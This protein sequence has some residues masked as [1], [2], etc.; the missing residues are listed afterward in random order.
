MTEHSQTHGPATG[1]RVLH[2]ARAYDLGTFLLSF[3]R[4]KRLR[5]E[6]IQRA[7]ITTG[8]SVLDVGAGTGTLTIAAKA[9]V[10]AAGHV[11]GIDPSPEMI[12]RAKQKAAKA[13]A[14]IDFRLGVIESLPFPDAS[15]DAVLSSL[16]LHHLPDDVK[17]QGF[18]EIARVLKP[19]GRFFAVDMVGGGHGPAGHPLG[20][21]LGHRGH[22]GHGAGGDGLQSAVTLLQAAGF[23]DIVTGRLDSRAMFG[24]LSATRA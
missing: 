24:F 22:G 21:V 3:G 4:E 23:K 15:F 12:E 2:S 6:T 8:Q 17:R 16:M 5:R 1:G 9:A 11:A 14:T 18:A 13:K 20:V 19:G 7:G 10:G